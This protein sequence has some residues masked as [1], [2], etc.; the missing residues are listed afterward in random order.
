[1][2][3]DPEYKQI[4][5]GDIIT[6]YY[7]GYFKFLRSEDRGEM[8]PLFYFKRFADKN[9]KRFKANGKD[10]NCDAL[11][12]RKALPHILETIKETEE[13]LKRLNELFWEVKGKS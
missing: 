3:E 9:G 5:P 4:K 12:C 6:T 8:S 1:M 7:S 13:N 2:K 11:W 10:L